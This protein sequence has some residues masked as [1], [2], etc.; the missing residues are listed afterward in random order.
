VRSLHPDVRSLHPDMR[1]LHPD[2]RSLH[3]DVLYIGILYIGILYIGILY[4]G[5]LIGNPLLACFENGFVFHS[6]FIIHNSEFKIS[7]FCNL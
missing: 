5:T 4:I 7:V 1:S 2:V 6:E 3:P